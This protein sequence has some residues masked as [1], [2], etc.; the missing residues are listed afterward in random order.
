M[1]SLNKRKELTLKV[2]SIERVWLELLSRISKLTEREID[3]LE[4][5]IKK[6]SLLL[7]D[8]MKQPYLSQILFSTEA[9]K[10]YCQELEITDF[11]F[12]NLLG[13]LRKK[14]AIMKTNGVEDIYHKLIPAEEILIKFELESND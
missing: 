8:G 3:V 1:Q 14:S 6:R 13:S 12:T 10:Q 2:T 11:N 9:R 5:L 4:V 7:K